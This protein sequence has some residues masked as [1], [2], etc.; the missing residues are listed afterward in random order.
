MTQTFGR[1]RSLMKGFTPGQTGVIV[2]AVLGLILGAVF[3]TRWVAQPTWT[4]LFTNLSGSDASAI[5]EQLKSDN[6]Q[7]KLADGGSTVLVP[8]AQV[9]DLRVAMSGKG[10]LN[11]TDNGYSILDSQ[12]MTATDLQQNVAYQRALESELAKTL[13]AIQGVRTAIVHLAIPKK[14]V[15][16]SAQDHPTASVLLSLN[17]GTAMDRGQVRA[18]THLVGA[19]IPGL[20]PAQVTVT[21]GKGNLLSSQDSGADG[22]ASVAGDADQQTAQFED[23]MS[24]TVQGML[25]KVLGPGHAVVRVNAQLDYDTRATTSERYLNET[26]VPPLSEATATETYAGGANGAGGALG[27]TWPTLTPGTGASGAGS[28]ARSQR[29]VDNAVGKVVESAQAAPGGVKRLTVAVVLDSAAAKADPGV[30]QQL[31]G[32]AVGL[33]PTRGDTVQ[34]SSLPFDTTAAAEAKKEIAAATSAA[35]TAQYIDLGK[36]AGLI[37][38]AIVVGLVLLRRRGKRTATVEA[39]ASDLPD[40]DGLLLTSQGQLPPAL[41][42]APAGGQLALPGQQDAEAEAAELDAAVHRERLRDEVAQMVDNQPDEVAA[43]IQ[44]WLSQRKG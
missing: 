44:S 17:P 5:V 40:R 8:Q 41:T 21:D 38:A 15:F 28:Y 2:V 1:L 39:S 16:S 11:N 30:V 34:V 25:D 27:G 31:V 6:V 9:Y 12:G 43:V 35:K 23:R 29:T 19:S 42:A 24:T 32:N 10:L 36:K 33:D 7:Y 20:D 13:Q 4:P 18:V 37:L 3:L 26:S 14:D 22:A